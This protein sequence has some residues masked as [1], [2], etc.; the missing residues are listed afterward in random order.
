MKSIYLDYSATTPVDK[1]VFNSMVPYFC[2]TYGN[3]SSIHRHGQIAKAAIEESR[4]KIANFIGA[5]SSELFFM[6]SGTESDNHAIKGTAEILKQQGKNHLITVKTE[7]HAV[8]E[9]CDYLIKRDFNVT[10]LDVD[11]NGLVSIRDIQNSITPKTGLISIMYVNNEVGTINPIK[12]IGVIAKLNNIIFHTDAVQAFGKMPIDVRELNVD[13]LTIT[14]HKIYGPKGIGALYIRKG[15]EIEKL[16]HGGGQESGKRAGTESTA[17][18]VGFAK[19]AELVIKNKNYEQ[20][21]YKHFN[22]VLKNNIQ[23]EIPEAI[24]NNHPDVSIPNILNVSFDS[25]RTIIDGES[26]IQ[27]LDLAGISVTSGS[28]CT[29]GAIKPSHVLLAMGRNFETAKSTV[30]FSFGRYTTDDEIDYTFQIL[31]KTIERIRLPEKKS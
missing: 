7:H 27:N 11:E 29:S 12:E 14:A 20:N 16:L 30:R 1:E 3:P 31:K 15:L 6:G 19:A 10:F 18:I 23:K 17:L 2:E 25:A 9:S 5:R 24:F 4:E 21:K 26:L 8:L 22:E 13:L 28:A